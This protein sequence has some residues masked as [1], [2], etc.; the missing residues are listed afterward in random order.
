MRIIN[1]RDKFGKQTVSFDIEDAD[2]LEAT[3]SSMTFCPDLVILEYWWNEGKPW[4][5][6]GA[7]VSGQRRLA[8]GSLGKE[9]KK[10][11]YSWASS[12]RHIDKAPAWL[13]Q[14]VRANLPVNQG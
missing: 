11:S 3:Y 7:T 6:Y 2:D 14:M 13:Q 4:S 8:D 9:R 5:L 10:T 12:D 1:Q